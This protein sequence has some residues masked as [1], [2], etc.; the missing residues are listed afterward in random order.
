MALALCLFLAALQACLA[1]ENSSSWENSS[2]AL[3]SWN[4][5][6][7]WEL[8]PD[9]LP[10][11]DEEAARALL[12]L[13][14]RRLLFDFAQPGGLGALVGNVANYASGTAS[15]IASATGLDQVVDNLRGSEQLMQQ[16][17]SFVQSCWN[18]FLGFA[19][20][21]GQIFQSYLPLKP[22]FESSNGLL[23]LLSSTTHIHDLVVFVQSLLSTSGVLRALAS[24]SEKIM[25]A[26]GQIAQVVQMGMSR[27]GQL[28]M[29]RRLGGDERR[30][31]GYWD[32]LRGL[33]FNS[34]VNAFR[35]FVSQAGNWANTLDQ[36]NGIIGPI[37]SQV[38]R[39][40]GRR[41]QDLAAN[42]Q[43]IA[44]ALK[45][46]IP[47]WKGV[48]N[49]GMRMCPE[50]SVARG[51][52]NSLACRI[53]QFVGQGGMLS[54]LGN[55]MNQCPSRQ[56]GNPNCPSRAMSAGTSDMLSKMSGPLGWILAALIGLGV[57]GAGASAMGLG[58]QQGGYGPMGPGGGMGPMGPMGPG[59][60]GYGPP[61]GFG[62]P[63]Y[64]MPRF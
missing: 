31:F 17:M 30:L 28:G 64:E 35:T 8:R 5:S 10:S 2:A 11:F 49:L 4:A 34:L 16:A 18:T 15:R 19:S 44:W 50:V 20:K 13:E 55:L 12:P 3:E 53:Q 25:G 36:V 63:Q 42:Q 43:R 29:G 62:P 51:Q 22:V 26:F 38:G 52:G 9:E 21:M 47:A 32:M 39:M 1:L 59:G 57:V 56:A 58:G 41:L 54:M 27:L 60:G 6:S 14:G 40:T 61:G 48:E 24:V 23:T 33:D 7:L 45:Q 46:V 37:L